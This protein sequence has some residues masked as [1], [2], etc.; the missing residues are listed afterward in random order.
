MTS[1]TGATSSKLSFKDMDWYEIEKF[2]YRLQMRIAKA[3]Q[4]GRYGKVQALQYLLTRSNYAKLLAVKRVTSSTGKKTAG[5]DGKTCRSNKDKIQLTNSL[6]QRGYKAAP[7]RRVYIPKTN[8]KKRPL[9]IPTIQ[10]RAMQALYLLAL[11]PVAEMQADGH[12]YGFRP[13]RSTADAIE[14]VFR[15]F[16]H[17]HS[18]EFVLEGDIKGCF[19]N[20]S[21]EWLMNH[22]PIEKRILLQWLKAGYLEK[23]TLFQTFEGTP[24]GSVVSPLLANLVLDGLKAALGHRYQRRQHKINFIRYADDFVISGTSKEILED[25]VT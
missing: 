7:L 14:Q 20:I 12:S 6:R 8:G 9:G 19:D 23:Q 2:V 22:V 4:D 3:K 10:D 11:E 18:A 5:V 1:K 13:R 24:Q 25:V 16:L 21:H 17:K 15:V